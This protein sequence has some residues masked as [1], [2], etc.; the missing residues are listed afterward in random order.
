MDTN[1]KE[2]QNTAVGEFDKVPNWRNLIFNKQGK[3]HRGV[4]L[5][6]S[7]EK[8]RQ[9]IYE[10]ETMF[11]TDDCNAIATMDGNIFKDNYQY[12]IQMPV[13]S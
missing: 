8:A 10:I 12:A 5:F 3:S 9:R 7:I 1:T 6:S 11:S 13:M 2:K 4:L